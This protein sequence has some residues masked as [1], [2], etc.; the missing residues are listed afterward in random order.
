MLCLQLFVIFIITLASYTVLDICIHPW[1]GFYTVWGAMNTALFSFLMVMLVVCY[2]KAAFTSPG[3][4]PGRWGEDTG[5][6]GDV[7]LSLLKEPAPVAPLR[8]CAKCQA[9]KPPRCHHCSVCNKCVLKMDHHCPWINNCVGFANYKHFVLFLVYTVSTCVD[10]LLLMAGRVFVAKGRFLP[11]EVVCMLLLAII[12]VPTTI[13]VSCLLS[14]HVGIITENKTTIEFHGVG[15][16]GHF[17]RRSQPQ[18]PP[19]VYD[20]GLAKNCLQ[21]FGQSPCLWLCPTAPAGDG[22]S[23]ETPSIDDAMIEMA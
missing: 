3:H 1:F 16:A 21:V 7:E 5:D 22:C 11:G 10:T 15:H 6:T 13:L 8:H 23:F 17:R 14:Y 9:A 19:M 4:P 18:V 12:A 20:L 2:V